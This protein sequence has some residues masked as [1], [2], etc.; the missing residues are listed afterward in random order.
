MILINNNDCDLNF[1]LFVRQEGSDSSDSFFKNTLCILEFESYSG[2]VAARSKYIMRCRLRPTKIMN[3]QFVIE[4]RIVYPNETTEI[5]ENVIDN[6][7]K[8]D[9]TD[10]GT[11][12]S[13]T[14]ESKNDNKEV[15]SY[16]TLSGVYPKLSIIDVKAL[17]VA[18]NLSK[19]Y[20]WK[21]LSLNDLNSAMSC[22]PNP[23]EL[24]YSIAT[25]QEANRR[26]VNNTKKIID[27]NFSSASLNSDNTEIIIFIENSGVV[28]TEW[29]LLFP[30]DLLLELEYWAESGDYTIDELEEIKLQDNNIF[31]VTP[32][33]GHLEPG[34]IVQIKIIYKHIFMGQNKLPVLFKI[35]KGR[36]ISLNLSGYTGGTNEPSVFFPSNKF[37]F[38]PLEIGLN[39][40]P[41]QIYELYNGG[42]VPAIIEMDLTEIDDLNEQ[43]YSW[44]IIKCL[45]PSKFTIQPGA[46]Y[47]TKWKFSPTEA[48]TYYLTVTFSNGNTKQIVTFKFIGYDKRRIGNDFFVGNRALQVSNKQKILL[49]NQIA[50]L[51]LERIVFGEIPLFS[52]ERKLVFVRNN[53]FENKIEFN[54][55]ITNGNHIK[56]IRIQP[57]RGVIGPNQSRLCK[58]T[59]IAKELPSF[60]NIDLICEIKN[61]NKMKEYKEELDAWI[62]EQHRQFQEFLID[63]DELKRR[64]TAKSDEEPTKDNRQRTGSQLLTH[65]FK[66]IP[67]ILKNNLLEETNLDRVRRKRQEKKLWKKPEPPIPFLLHLDVIARTQH[68][69]DYLQSKN[70]IKNECSKFIDPLLGQLQS[71]NQIK[72][73]KQ[74]GEEEEGKSIIFCNEDEKETVL[75]IISNILRNLISDKSFNNLIQRTKDEPVPYFFQYCNNGD[76]D[77]DAD[78]SDGSFIIKKE[79]QPSIVSSGISSPSPL[80]P[81]SSSIHSKNKSI[82]ESASFSTKSNIKK[83]NLKKNKDD[84]NKNQISDQNIKTLPLFSSFVESVLENTIANILTEAFNKEF[85]LTSRPRLIALPPK[86]QNTNSNNQSNNYKTNTSVLSTTSIGKSVTPTVASND[87]EII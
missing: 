53:S 24:M 43:N 14:N 41:I 58:I 56:Y 20:L 71:L 10:S 22:E 79:R 82:I 86:T 57:S 30:K 49:P 26:L 59:F 33:R 83:K 51:S 46:M 15:L 19:D 66:T 52:R 55:H 6:N 67:P 73:N 5:Q 45:T 37:E 84:P 72:L 12:L 75:F 7:E 25:R 48:K 61:D 54:W 44:P 8:S 47:E 31:T 80:S 18:A 27:L 13:S 11:H 32:K 28:A 3:Y 63:E 1:E 74:E 9:R 64:L 70:I 77:S 65:N 62:H 87:N 29:A 34:E 36:E 76:D 16:M 50:S 42:D 60:Y 85:S 81:S 17:G 38:E 35:D 78:N 39:E 68:F 69:D 4:Y 2:V 21:L 40:Y 23:D